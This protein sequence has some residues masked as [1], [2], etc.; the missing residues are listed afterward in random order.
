MLRHRSCRAACRRLTAVALAAFVCA[1]APAQ[2]FVR[3]PRSFQVGPH[4]S[5]IVAADLNG[6]GIPDIVTANTGMLGDPRD[7][8]PANDQLSVLMSD[9]R[10]QYTALPPLQ[11]GFAPYA[12]AVANMD[13]LPALDLVVGSFMAT[14]GWDVSIFRNLGD[15]L[16]EPVHFAVPDDALDYRRMRDGDGFPLF[17]TPGVTSVAVADF[18][19]DTYRDVVA[20]GWSSDVLIYFPGAADRYLGDPRLLPSPGGPRVVRAADIDGDG[21]MDIAVLLYISQEVALWRDD[22]A[23]NFELAERFPTRGRLPQ[24]MELA[25]VTGNGHLDIVVSHAHSDDSVVLFPG[26]GSFSFPLSQEIMLG[27]KRD[28][29]EHEIRDIVVADLNGNGKKDIAAACHGSATVKVLLNQSTAP[30]L[31]I[32]FRVETYSFG[33]GRPRALAAA[34]FDG[35]GKMDLAVALWGDNRVGFLLGR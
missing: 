24:S 20:A 6:N 33:D 30:S 14:R 1:A 12:I 2:T 18:N 17:T 27:S 32:S 34:D 26:T 8:R 15:N 5:A 3:S 29:L 22:G 19:R 9:G 4:P 16:F 7:E 35:D 31:P 28:V 25:D 13:H 23:G 21:R 11:T 10:M